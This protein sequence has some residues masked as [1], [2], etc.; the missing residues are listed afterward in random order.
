MADDDDEEE[1]SSEQ[2]TETATKLPVCENDVDTNLGGTQK[3]IENPNAI[4]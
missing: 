1:G 2:N 3:T 4:V